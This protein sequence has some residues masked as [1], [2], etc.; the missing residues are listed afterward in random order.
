MSN[1]VESQSSTLFGRIV[2][3]RLELS[4]VGRSVIR[5]VAVSSVELLEKGKRFGPGDV[6]ALSEKAAGNPVLKSPQRG[7]GLST[8]RPSETWELSRKSSVYHPYGRLELAFPCLAQPMRYPFAGCP[9]VGDRPHSV[10]GRPH[11]LEAAW[12]N[13]V[14]ENLPLSASKDKVARP[15]TDYSQRD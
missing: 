8:K 15:K 4:G 1:H 10:A 13:S 7:I 6:F 3:T 11:R 5:V 14:W 9:P 12:V 2:A